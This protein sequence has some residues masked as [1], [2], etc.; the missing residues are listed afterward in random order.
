MIAIDGPHL[1]GPALP[2]DQRSFRRAL[3][4]IALVIDDAGK[5][6]EH[7]QGGTAG[8]RRG[9][10]GEG[11]DHHAAGF[12]LPPGI[13]DRAAPIAHDIVVPVPG[14]GIDRLAHG[15]EQF[16][17]AAAGAGDVFVAFA[18]EGPQGGGGGIELRH[19]ILVDDLPESRVIGP[20]RHALE[21]H[22]GRAVQQRTV[23]NIGMAGH[24]AHIGSAPVD[25]AR[26]VVEYIFMRHA[27][28]HGIAAGGVQHAL[29]LSGGAGGIKNEERILGV[30][31]LCRA[32]FRLLR[33]GG[34]PINV[35]TRHHRHIRA[36]AR[37]HDHR[38]HRPALRL[39]FFQ[40]GIHIG[41]ERNDL[42]APAPFVRG[43]DN[44]A[45]AIHDAARQRLGRETGE[46]H[47]MHG[48]DARAGEHC[49]GSLGHHG[50]IDR[51]PVALPGALRLQSIGE[52][53]NLAIEFAIG[54]A[55]RGLLRIV[56]LPDDGEILTAFN[57]VPVQ[58]IGSDVERSTRKPADVQIV[59]CEARILHLVEWLDPV[60][61]LRFFA[62]EGIGIVYRLPIFAPVGVA[63]DKG[64]LRPCRRHVMFRFAHRCL[65]IACLPNLRLPR[66]FFPGRGDYKRPKRS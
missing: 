10:A 64:V 23:N 62:P 53:A 9:G 60:D 20:V 50:Q 41:L 47:R 28:P 3:L 58:T 6:P 24:P 65:P 55:A 13:D 40:R 63:I 17:A 42:P 15:S 7:R 34:S 51:D 11:S 33:A 14:F 45:V 4:Q 37:E 66:F 18:H 12:R 30:H 39:R 29:G 59:F 1:A 25:F 43:D 5:H 22:G 49:H 61:A 38:F 46:D 57:L 35:A 56:R 52:A 36:G 54:D 19:F 44:A 26:A 32:G 27:G 21:H 48:T 2:D 16:Q 31:L 8:L